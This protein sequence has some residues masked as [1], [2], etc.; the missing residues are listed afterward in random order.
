MGR[1]VLNAPQQQAVT[2]FGGPLLV[3]A[4]AGAGKT[5]VLTQR[6]L[7]FIHQMGIPGDRI[8]AI[9]FTNKAAA[10]MKERT[11]AQLAHDTPRPFIGTFHSFCHHVLRRSIGSLGRS[12]HFTII[13]TYDQTKLMKQLIAHHQLNDEKYQPAWVLG[14]IDRLKNAM[15]SPESYARDPQM[16]RVIASMYEAYQAALWAQNALDFN[17]LIAL[18]VTLLQR[19]PSVLSSY[20][21][22]YYVML[23][24]EYQDTNPSQFALLHLLSQKYRN[25]TAVGDFDQSIYSWRGASVHTLLQFESH[26]P[27]ATVIKLEE[28]YRSTQTILSAANALIAHNTQRKEKTLWT[29][30]DKG[31]ALP[32]LACEDEW[33]EAKRITQLIQTHLQQ[34]RPPQD[35]AIL[36]RTNAQTRVIEKSLSMYQIPYMVIGGFAFMDRAEIK[37]IGAYLRCLLNPH[38]NAAVIRALG[39]PPRGIGQTSIEKLMANALEKQLSIAQLVATSPPLLTSRQ[40]GILEGFFEDLARWQRWLTDHSGPTPIADL[41][42]QIVSDTHYDEATQKEKGG[43]DRLEVIDELIHLATEELT[44]LD[45]FVS[46]LSL[47]GGKSER[48]T[49]AVNILTLHHAKGLEYPIVFLTG[50][51]Q[52]ILP[53]FRSIRDG[54][55]EEERRLCYVGITRGK[56]Q[57]T[58]SYAASRMVQGDKRRSSPS[59]FLDE[60]PDEL[61]ERPP[62]HKKTSPGW[63]P[64]SERKPALSQAAAHSPVHYALHDRVR[65]SRWGDGHIVAIH[66]EG[67]EAVLTISFGGSVK[68]LMVKYAPLSR[69]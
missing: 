38:D 21:D 15:I 56:E 18:T 63:P 67:D 33:D 29:Q 24:D 50:M 5:L 2:H 46:G 40:W 66:G 60:L 8:L 58:L 54:D 44:S 35:I 26:F 20:Q 4:G 43:A 45:D 49:E 16:D 1:P 3:I 57:V 34:G 12:P 51:E 13:D 30:R 53:H 69:T 64:R 6:M 25:I 17:D 39:A 52:G 41:I 10:E 32:I 68:R 55:I 9:T 36:V 19:D 11:H 48:T 22:Q 27:D 7:F 14:I 61:V 65:H 37:D 47:G 62:D 23:V 59:Q 31:V 42:R 28:N